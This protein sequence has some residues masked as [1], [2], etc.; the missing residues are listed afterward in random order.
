MT[1]PPPVHEFR[2]KYRFLSNFFLVPGGL[3]VAS[4]RAATTEHFYQAA[5]TENPDEA[6]RVLRADSPMAAKRLGQ[7]VMIR[8]DW[9]ELRV[10]V[11]HQI[12]RV[13]FGPDHP[14]LVHQLLATGNRVLIEGNTWGDRFWGVDTRTNVGLNRLGTLLMEIRKDLAST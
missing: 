6:E 14:E 3:V 10:P 8:P 11:M 7:Q 9:N 2:G 12:L 5:K 13:K 1:T 4:K